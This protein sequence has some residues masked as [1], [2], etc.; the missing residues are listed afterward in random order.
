MKRI[1]K[2]SVVKNRS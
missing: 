2:Q 1:A